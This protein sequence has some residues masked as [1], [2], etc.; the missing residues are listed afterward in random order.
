MEK[1]TIK[2]QNDNQKK[3]FDRKNSRK[4]YSLL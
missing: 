4:K 3:I 2:K 1:K